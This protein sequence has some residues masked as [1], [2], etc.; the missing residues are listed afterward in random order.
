MVL[1]GNECSNALH[2]A[3]HRELHVSTLMGF[4]FYTRKIKTGTWQ[5]AGGNLNGK[6]QV[7]LI[8]QSISTRTLRRNITE[9]PSKKTSFLTV[10]CFSLK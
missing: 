8:N 3:N 7:V 2:N 1:I 9:F 5:L 4:W 6:L 10:K